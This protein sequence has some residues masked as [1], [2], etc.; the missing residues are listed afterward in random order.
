MTCGKYYIKPKKKK[1]PIKINSQIN[2]QFSNNCEWKEWEDNI[3]QLYSYTI[4]TVISSLFFFFQKNEYKEHYTN[5]EVKIKKKNHLVKTITSFL[6]CVVFKLKEYLNLL[7][8]FLQ[9]KKIK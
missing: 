1:N 7:L 9:E 6:C 2:R 8:K 4:N 3:L 5:L